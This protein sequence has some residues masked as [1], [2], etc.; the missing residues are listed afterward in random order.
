MDRRESQTAVSLRSV[1]R[2]R[3]LTAALFSKIILY[4]NLLIQSS[5]WLMYCRVLYLASKIVAT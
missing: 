2:E 4:R 1:M 3:S 5:E